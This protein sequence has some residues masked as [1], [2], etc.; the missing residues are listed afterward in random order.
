[1]PPHDSKLAAKQVDVPTRCCEVGRM[2]YV[3]SFVGGINKVSMH[4]GSHPWIQ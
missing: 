1:M 3:L 2:T 4:I